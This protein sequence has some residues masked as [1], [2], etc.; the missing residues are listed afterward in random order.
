M[1]GQGGSS[2]A[3]G[4]SDLKVPK[5][6]RLATVLSGLSAQA[7]L[8]EA[9]QA[10]QQLKSTKKGGEQTLV[11]RTTTKRPVRMGAQSGARLQPRAG[12]CWG[13]S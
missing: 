1:N 7:D 3:I 8:E 10:L 4:K 5:F 6:E 11:R 12:Q 13:G 9:I 2:G